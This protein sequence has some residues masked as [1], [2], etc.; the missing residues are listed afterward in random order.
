MQKSLYYYVHAAAAHSVNYTKNSPT[1]GDLKHEN[2]TSEYELHI[3]DRTP[4]C[5]NVTDQTETDW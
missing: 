4:F 1:H 3:K 5:V 2:E